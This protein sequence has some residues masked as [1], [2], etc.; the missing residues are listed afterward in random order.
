MSRRAWT[1][2]NDMGLPRSSHARGSHMFLKRRRI[3]RA[4]RT[5]GAH[6]ACAGVA[7]PAHGALKH[8]LAT[9]RRTRWRTRRTASRGRILPRIA[10]RD[11]PRLIVAA[12]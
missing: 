4:A 12:A 1:I 2:G 9:L 5:A 3:K 7:L 10:A 11:Q 6:A 8:T